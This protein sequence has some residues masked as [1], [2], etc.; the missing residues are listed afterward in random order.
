[1]G[2]NYGLFEHDEGSGLLWKIGGGPV[3]SLYDQLVAK[4]PGSGDFWAG[5]ERGL[6]TYDVAT[7]TYPSALF[8]SYAHDQDNR[9]VFD[10]RLL[11][12]GHAR[13]PTSGAPR[14]VYAVFRFDPGQPPTGGHWETVITKPGSSETEQTIPDL[15]VWDVL[16]R[17]P[18]EVDVLASPIDPTPVSVPASSTNDSPPVITSFVMASYFP[19]EETQVLRWTARDD[20]WSP[21]RTLAGIPHVGVGMPATRTAFSSS[22]VIHRAVVALD[23]EKHAAPV[24]V[25]RLG[26]AFVETPIDW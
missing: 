13:L 20:V 26:D 1:M 2:R 3:R 21:I 24:L 5:I 8:V 23:S 25:M 12:P 11:H 19:K 15:V 7:A 6:F 17:E 10:G 4:D 14:M 16:E 9:A 22:G 18:G